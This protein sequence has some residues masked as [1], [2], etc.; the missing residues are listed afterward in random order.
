MNSNQKEQ[1]RLLELKKLQV[2]NQDELKER[3]KLELKHKEFMSLNYAEMEAK[4]RIQGQTPIQTGVNSPF[5][6]DVVNDYKEQYAQE[7]W[8]EEPVANGNDVNFKFVSEEALTNFFMKLSEKEIPFVM[9]DV[10]TK[11]VMAYSNGDGQLYHANGTAVKAGDPVKPSDIDE[12]G[13]EIPNLPPSTTN[14]P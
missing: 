10:A 14:T 4:L 13:F 7:S 3:I 1:M 6:D 2:L 8:Y 9:Y 5:I 11:K 12:Q